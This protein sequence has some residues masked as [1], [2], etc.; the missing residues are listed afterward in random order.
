MRIT[1]FLRNPAVTQDE[2]IATAFGRTQAAC[3]G[4]EV[5]AVQEHHR[6]AGLGPRARSWTPPKTRA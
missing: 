1:R 2:M 6:N 5:L 4:R 3:A